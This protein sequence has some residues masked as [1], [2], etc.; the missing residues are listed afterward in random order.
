M[1]TTSTEFEENRQKIEKRDF[2]VPRIM[3]IMTGK[4][5]FYFLFSKKEN[6]DVIK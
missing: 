6:K 5:L 4:R 2:V 3:R 1:R